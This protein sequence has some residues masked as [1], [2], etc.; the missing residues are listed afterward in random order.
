MKFPY[1]FN[2]GVA[3]QSCW[4][5]HYP[6]RYLPSKWYI[7][8]PNL[9]HQI[10]EKQ[11]LHCLKFSHFAKPGKGKAILV[12]DHGGPYGCQ[13]LRLQ[14]FLDNRLTDG[15]EIVSLT[16]RPPFT[17]G[18]I[19]GIIPPKIM[20]TFTRLP[21]FPVSEKCSSAQYYRWYSDRLRFGRSDFG[22]QQEQD[23]FLSPQRPVRLRGPPSLL[24]Y[25]FR[26][27]SGR[28]VKLTT[29]FH[30]VLRSRI[31]EI[32]LRSPIRL[33]GVVLN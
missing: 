16:R 22:F 24:F 4:S 20:H 5:H 29:H 8:F 1:C 13:T 21:I 17:P 7:F 15:G 30:L 9:W 32:Y 31:L 25:G 19:P 11:W 3:D 10:S 18:K 12:T 2:N 23:I 14:D 27:K 33:G 28:G 26:G 6:V